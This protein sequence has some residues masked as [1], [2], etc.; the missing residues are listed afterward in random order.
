M[1]NAEEA[2]DF[3]RGVFGTDYAQPLQRFGDVTSES[4]MAPLSEDERDKVLHVELPILA[5]HLIM[6]TDVLASMGHQLRI[7]N[8]TTINL[9]PDSREETDRLYNALSEGS[10]EGS[11]MNEM[12]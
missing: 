4:V 5:G 9:E 11:G 2:F 12:F 7:G 3:Y 8:N 1:G 6:G 10:S